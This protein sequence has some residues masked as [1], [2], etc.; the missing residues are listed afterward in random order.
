MESTIT[1][2]LEIVYDILLR[3]PAKSL[4]RFKLVSK[5]WGSLISDPN[6]AESH[7]RRVNTS[8]DNVN[9]LRVGQIRAVTGPRPRL[10]LYSM[11]SDGLNREIVKLDYP[12]G[13]NLRHARIL[14]SC[15]GLLLIDTESCAEYFLWNPSTGKYKTI[16]PP[17]IQEDGEFISGLA[18]ES[19]SRNYKGIIVS[20][21]VSGPSSP[22]HDNYGN[23][24]SL[25]YRVYDYQKNSWTS[26]DFCEFSYRIHTSSTAVMVNG[27][28]HWCVY[29]RKLDER[30]DQN[31]A[32][33]LRL[34][35]FHVTYVI[36]YFDLKNENFKEVEL[37]MW[38]TQ[39]MKFDLGVLGGCLSMSL[40][41]H[42]SFTEV[43]AMKEY[44]IPESWTKLFVISSSFG[45]LRPVCFPTNNRNKVLLKVGVKKLEK[46]KKEGVEKWI[47]F[48][49]KEEITERILLLKNDNWYDTYFSECTYV[50][51]LVF[52][53]EHQTN[54]EELVDEFCT[55]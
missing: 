50:G 36:I 14:G 48:N 8:Q 18:Y 29:R 45:K 33:H 10:S 25:C 32:Q 13:D 21:Y 26:K 44:G 37:P 35:Y 41:P 47:I 28:P 7:L 34:F 12:F 42:G 20:H 2:V 53:E 16:P 5:P 55:L 49:L 19:T 24:E 54:H 11:D 3:L 38:A 6:F 22:S 39:E 31:Y 15:N 52:P 30:N 46:W 9:L 40:N 1:L 17:F 27:V 43:W 23:Y 51:S 4:Q